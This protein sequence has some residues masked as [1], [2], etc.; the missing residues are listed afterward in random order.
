MRAFNLHVS[1]VMNRAISKPLHKAFREHFI[2]FMR[3]RSLRDEIAVSIIVIAA[4]KIAAFL[5]PRQNL[6]HFLSVITLVPSL[7]YFLLFF[8]TKLNSIGEGTGQ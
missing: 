7:C 5:G 3:G 4:E 2:I 6:G 8:M 1:S